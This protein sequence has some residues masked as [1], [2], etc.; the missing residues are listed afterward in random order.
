MLEGS[1]FAPKM[2]AEDVAGIIVYAA[3][4]APLAMNGSS[5]EAFGP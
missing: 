1:G 4:E 5:I 3:L 2:S